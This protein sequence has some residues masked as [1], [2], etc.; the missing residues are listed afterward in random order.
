M[1]LLGTLAIDVAEVCCIEWQ[2]PHDT[3]KRKQQST[4]GNTINSADMQISA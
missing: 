3:D 1:F 4:S 2:T